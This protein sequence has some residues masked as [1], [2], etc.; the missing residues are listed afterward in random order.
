MTTRTSV[1]C[2]NG[3]FSSPKECDK[4]ASKPRFKR[5]KCG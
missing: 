3:S 4:V 1:V 5:T 2:D